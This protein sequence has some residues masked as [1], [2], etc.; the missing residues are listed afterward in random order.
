MK[1]LVIAVLTIGGFACGLT[2]DQKA[3]KGIGVV[4]ELS[5]LAHTVGADAIQADCMKKA[6]VCNSA[7][8]RVCKPAEDCLAKRRAFDS[9]IKA[10]LKACKLAS[11]SIT[12]IAATLREF[13]VAP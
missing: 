8:D 4:F 5:G 6:K 9:A 12:A 2:W 7:G 3:H 11:D 13:G 10:A 1:Y